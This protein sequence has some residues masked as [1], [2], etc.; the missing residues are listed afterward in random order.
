MTRDERVRVACERFAEGPPGGHAET[1]D[2]G[3]EAALDAALSDV[4]G[5]DG[6]GLLADLTDQSRPL[7][8]RKAALLTTEYY[9]RLRADRDRF[10]EALRV[11][12]TQAM[13][14]SLNER[15]AQD[16]LRESEA[17]T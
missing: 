15:T 6:L 12:T 2:Q 11:I 13:P 9:A 10:R 5:L 8:D 4:G 1:V 3:I 16:A 7:E 14:G 17:G